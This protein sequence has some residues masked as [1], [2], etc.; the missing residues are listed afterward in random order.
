MAALSRDSTKP[1]L[2]LAEAAQVAPAVMALRV[3]LPFRRSCRSPRDP[4]IL[5]P[6]T[7]NL[8]NGADA[9]SA[10]LT[11]LGRDRFSRIHAGSRLGEPFHVWHLST[12]IRNTAALFMPC[13][14]AASPYQGPVSHMFNLR[15]AAQHAVGH[16]PDVVC[17]GRLGK[18]KGLWRTSNRILV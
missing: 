13:R 6:L 8:T 16:V 17:R 12:L 4:A 10:S 7:I 14:T 18:L 2:R 11:G 5:V 15:L 9:Y 3:R 1:S